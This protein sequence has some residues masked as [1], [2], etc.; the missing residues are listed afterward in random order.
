ME[1]KEVANRLKSA[2]VYFKM[3]FEEVVIRSVPGTP[4]TFFA[5]F[6]GEKDW[7]IASSSTTVTNA[8]LE[9]NEITHREYIDF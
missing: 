4:T 5:K 2:P 3:E 8:L 7:P 9:W 6:Q 1:A